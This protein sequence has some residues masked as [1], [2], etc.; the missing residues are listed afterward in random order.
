MARQTQKVT[1]FVREQVE[2]EETIFSSLDMG[3]EEEDNLPYEYERIRLTD[4]EDQETYTGRPVM[5]EV[6]SFTIDDDG[7]EVTKYRCKLYLIDDEEEEMLEININLKKYGDVQTNIRKGAVLYDFITSIKDLE[8]PGFAS[9]FNRINKVDL[10]EFRD[11]INGCSEA[12]LKCL[13]RQ[14]GNFVYN[15]FILTKIKG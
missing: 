4:L 10:K 13:E 9:L 14:G 3:Y 1:E 7:E 11:F 2:E 6:Q 5:T 8:S 15:Y 12:T